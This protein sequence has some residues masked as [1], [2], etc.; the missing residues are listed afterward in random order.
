VDLQETG[1]GVVN[2]IDLAQNKDKWRA[3]VNTVMKLLHPKMR[4]FYF[5]L[6]KELSAS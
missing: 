4:E 1:R 5:V 2:W 6:A 3:V